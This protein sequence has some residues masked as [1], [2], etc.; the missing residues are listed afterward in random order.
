MPQEEEEAGASGRWRR[1][2]QSDRAEEEGVGAEEAH[3]VTVHYTTSLTLR[4]GKN[5]DVIKSFMHLLIAI[6]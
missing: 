4:T 6:P 3:A 1:A 2:H 5:C